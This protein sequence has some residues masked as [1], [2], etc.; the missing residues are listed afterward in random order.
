[1][2]RLS[3]LGWAAFAALAFVLSVVPSLTTATA[4]TTRE[5]CH[6]AITVRQWACQVVVIKGP[7]SRPVPNPPASTGTCSWQGRVY[8][9]NDQGLGWFNNQN[10]CYFRLS[11]PQP[12]FDSK[13]WQG[14][15][16]GQGAIF[17]ETCVAINRFG[18]VWQPTSPTGPAGNSPAQL[19]QQ[20]FA[21]LTL[22]KPVP[23]T[24]PSGARLPDGRPY[25][26]VQVPTWYW[27]TPA[28]YVAKTARAA[29]GPVWAQVTVIPVALTFAPG[30]TGSTKSC[31]GPGTVWTPQAGPW[32]YSPAGC[33][34]AYPQ[35]TYGYPGGQLTATY[36]IV[37]R[38]TWTGSGGTGGGFPD[39]TTTATA[40]FAVAEAQAVIVK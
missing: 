7:D 1:M 9:C 40:R 38:A 19:A 2:Y 34:Y 32:A 18:F 4:A 28:S 8:P 15:Q 30:D 21:T 10:G 39:V 13:L 22:P 14:H 25:T 31:A 23:P 16:S 20:A 24:S 33:D 5:G 17:A 35:S 36:G 37:W 6:F 12:A 27:T 26:V 11:S 29:V 3:W